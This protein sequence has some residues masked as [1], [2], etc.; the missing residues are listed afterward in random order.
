MA[1]EIVGKLYKKFDTENKTDTF[2]AREFIL[3][4]DEASGY[5]QYI[6]FQLTQDR[7]SL[8]DNYNE[9]DMIKVHFDL[10]GREWNEKFFT[11]LNAWRIEEAQA[12]AGDELLPPPEEELPPMPDE[13]PDE[14][15]FDNHADDAQD[16][17]PF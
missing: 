12:T 3:L 17:L 9:G 4:I 2:R 8:I 5:P 10:R 14:L 11:N 1:F 15:N 6:K 7:C 13:V 16:D